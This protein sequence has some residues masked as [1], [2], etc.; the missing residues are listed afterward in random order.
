MID[1][2]RDLHTAASIS[3]LWLITRALS[4]VGDPGG[5][6]ETTDDMVGFAARLRREPL[7]RGRGGVLYTSD[8][9]I[10]SAVLRSPD[11]STDTPESRNP[12][13]SILV[14]PPTPRDQIDP[15]QDAIIARNGT[16]HA[17]I[18]SLVQPAFTNRVMQSW[19][20]AAERITQHIVDDFPRDGRVDLVRDWA[21]PLPLAM[22]C[23]IL[24]VPFSD[25]ATFSAW[26][27]ALAAGLDR[28]RSLG[29][30]RE[31]AQASR[32]LTGYLAALLDDR[33][34][35]PE[36]DLLSVLATA[37]VDGEVLDDRDIIATSSFL[38]LAGFETTVNLLGA[39]TRLLLD[40]RDQL[41]QVSADPTLIPALTEEALRYLSPVQYTFRTVLT[42]HELPGGLPLKEHQTVILLLA[43]ANRDPRVFA[44]P[45]RFDIHR[46]NARRHIA[47]GFGAHHCLGAALARME[48]EVAWKH[49]FE[50][51]PDTW[52]WE[53]AGEPVPNR[54][55]VINGLQ[56]LPVRLGTPAHV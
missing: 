22:I 20:D 11:A 2:K 17:R 14:G 7:V 12:L 52:S 56:S 4:L 13:M 3:L 50:R 53:L 48:A 37:E 30:A 49:L 43:G 47:L 29:L 9:E 23:E 32:A 54:G 38:L 10:C 16:E 6:L 18:R 42:S 39:G 31:R 21:A 40:H 19:R 28:P 15:I 27:N 34:R 8:Y 36:D 1:V 55:R 44:D 35:H 33:R 26:G 5:K 24:G 51:F 41:A 45:D 46:D 25:R